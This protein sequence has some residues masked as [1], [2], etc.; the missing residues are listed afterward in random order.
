M[1]SE[2]PLAVELLEKFLKDGIKTRTRKDLVQRHSFRKMLEASIRKYKARAIESAKVI[3]EL[4]AGEGNVRGRAAGRPGWTIGR[5][6]VHSLWSEIARLAEALVR[7]KVTDED[8]IVRAT[9]MPPVA[10]LRW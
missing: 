6:R 5:R 3:E 2:L 8:E 4:I 10:W 9:R 7:L 1:Q